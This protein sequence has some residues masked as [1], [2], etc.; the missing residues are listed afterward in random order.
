MK[1]VFKARKSGFTLVELL[2]VTIIIGILAGMMMLTMGS[3]TDG[4]AASKI[5]NDLRL[6]KS[7]SLLFYN[8]EGAWPD[9][10]S[11]S[12]FVDPRVI[13]EDHFVAVARRKHQIG[14]SP[15]KIDAIQ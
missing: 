13:N 1:N 14:S 5:I 15:P 4:A 2:I 11:A 8:D 10:T 12:P 6:L 7:A 9:T 3:A